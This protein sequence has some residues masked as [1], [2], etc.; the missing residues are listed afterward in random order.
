MSCLTRTT[1]RTVVEKRFGN[2]KSLLSSVLEIHQTGIAVDRGRIDFL[3]SRFL[4]AK[5]NMEKE[6]RDIIKWPDFNIRS[7]Q[8]VKEFL[9]GHKLNGKIDKDT[10]KTIRI[11]PEGAISLN[12]RP[13][14]DTSKPPKLWTE[15]I[16]VGKTDEH[17]PFYR[18]ASVEFACQGARR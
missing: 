15:I 2:R 4:E 14:F 10:G 11:R 18:Q 13:I 1:K 6:L 17:S 3:T 7:T 5:L 16:K 12:L 9:F 8:H